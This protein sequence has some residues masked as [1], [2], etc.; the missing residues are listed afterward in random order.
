MQEGRVLSEDKREVADVRC[1]CS[2]FMLLQLT[3]LFPHPIPR[4][5]PPTLGPMLEPNLTGRINGPHKQAASAQ[6]RLR[7]QGRKRN[8][9][10]AKIKGRE[11]GGGGREEPMSG[12]T[13]AR[14]GNMRK[15]NTATSSLSCKK[16][17]TAF[18]A[19][20][21]MEVK[22]QFPGLESFC[23]HSVLNISAWVPFWFSSFLPQSKNM[24]AKPIGNSK[25]RCF[26][27]C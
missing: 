18:T 3:L 21:H 27:E 5:R 17:Q 26:C 12:L 9:C 13:W 23:V 16:S 2:S 6:W 20:G 19:V 24:H 14:Q 1:D 4:C 8:W 22:V 11:M 15:Q 10:N 25:L 7:I